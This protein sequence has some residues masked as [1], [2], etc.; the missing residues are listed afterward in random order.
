MAQAGSHSLY[1]PQW[2]TT[3]SP[4]IE[5]EVLTI[6]FHGHNVQYVPEAL[7]T[8]LGFGGAGTAGDTFQ[9][10]SEDTMS[11][12]PNSFQIHE[13]ALEYPVILFSSSNFSVLSW[14]D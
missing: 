7:T 4:P 14:L 2:W 3:R 1:G 6:S 8:R 9:N 11:L 10:L 13:Q 12:E 5:H